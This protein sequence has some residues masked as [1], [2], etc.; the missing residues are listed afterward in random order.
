M[1]EINLPEF[2]RTKQVFQPLHVGISDAP[3]SHSD[4]TNQVTTWPCYAT[5]RLV[6]HPQIP[7]RTLF[8]I[9]ADD[10]F[11]GDDFLLE[12]GLART[13]LKDPIKK[14]THFTS[15]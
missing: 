11:I 2:S 1:E 13:D 4:V 3:D 10:S 5:T 7:L 6:L 8:N 15:D 14:Q 9:S 12:S